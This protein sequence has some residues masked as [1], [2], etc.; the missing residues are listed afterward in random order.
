MHPDLMKVISDLLSSDVHTSEN[1]ILAAA[2]IQLIFLKR[3]K[4]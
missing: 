1:K 3:I 2:S 4:T